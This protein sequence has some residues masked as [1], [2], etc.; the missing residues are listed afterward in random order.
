MLHDLN[1][2]RTRIVKRPVLST[3]EV[4]LRPLS[5]SHKTHLM[6]GYVHKPYRETYAML[7]RHME[8]DSLLLVRGTE[9]GIV[10]SFRGRAHIV[11]TQGNDL[12]SE[13]DIELAPIGLDREYRAEDIPETTKPAVE[14]PDRIGMKWDIE[15][16]SS[17]CA[18]AGLRALADEPGPAHDAAVL[19][20]AM[21]LWHLGK[22][23]TMQQATDAAREAIGSGKAMQHLKKGL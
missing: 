9:G 3:T 16:L 14:S 23:K 22:A 7:A 8:Y 4:M 13:L 11:R 18:E 1:E 21:A 19:G 17:M 2:L 5:G 12:H 10:P 15:T 6:T 20:S